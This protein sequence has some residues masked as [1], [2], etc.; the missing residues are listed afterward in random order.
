MEFEGKKFMNASTTNLDLATAEEKEKL[1]KLNEENKDMFATMKEAIPEMK[2]IR[3]TS[4]LKNH[5]VCLVSD[6]AISVEMEK[7]INAM[8]TDEK[9]KASTILEINESHPIAQKLKDLYKK[10]KD[11]LKEYTKILSNR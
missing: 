9:I 6:G 3:F 11:E 7:V 1:K 4:R 5:P 10:D 8:P 2:E